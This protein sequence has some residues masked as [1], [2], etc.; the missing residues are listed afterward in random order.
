[1]P[2]LKQFLSFLWA[3]RLWWLIPVFA[4]LALVGVLML[5][6]DSSAVAPF[7]YPLF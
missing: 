1:M 6:S 3:R 2:V 5:L 7:I 4:F